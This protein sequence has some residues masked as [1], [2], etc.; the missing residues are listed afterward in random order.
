MAARSR[1]RWESRICS[2]ERP[3]WPPGNGPS[4]PGHCPPRSPPCASTGADY[5]GRARSRRR[6]RPPSSGESGLARRALCTS[7]AAGLGRAEVSTE[8]QLEQ[9][10]QVGGELVRLADDEA[11]VGG[12]ED[13]AGEGVLDG[14]R[15]L[16]TAGILLAACAEEAHKAPG[17]LLVVIADGG[18]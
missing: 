12:P 13:R 7:D 5:P 1:S 15:K 18:A 4:S 9:D 8:D 16:R 3:W 11:L 17:G 10:G 6:R 14:V 2:R